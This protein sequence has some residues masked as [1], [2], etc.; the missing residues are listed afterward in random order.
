MN[1]QFVLP[2][3]FVDFQEMQNT[4]CLFCGISSTDKLDF[5]RIP[6][7][8]SAARAIIFR[9][10]RKQMGVLRMFKES[11]LRR[12]SADFGSNLF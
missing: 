6:V 11:D 10:D 3:T 2:N 1:K 4:Y 5:L 8:C 9:T 12:V 7:T